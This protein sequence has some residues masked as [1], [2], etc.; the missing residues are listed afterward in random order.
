MPRGETRLGRSRSAN[1]IVIPGRTASRR[2]SVIQADGQGFVY[3]DMEPTNPTLINDVAIVGFHTLKEG[4][5]ILIGDVV[6][7]FTLEGDR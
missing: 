6:L 7:R 4:D 2:H 5:R 1:D 3:Y